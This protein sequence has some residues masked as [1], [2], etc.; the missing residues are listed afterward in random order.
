MT[1]TT[2]RPTTGKAGIGR[3]LLVGLVAGLVAGI[4]NL[5]VYF[6]SRALGAPFLVPLGDPTS[7]PVDLPIFAVVMACVMPGLIA[8]LVYWA[9]GR[10]TRNATRIFLI[11]SAVIAVV[12]LFPP[13]SLPID[14]GTRLSL[15]LMHLVAAP[16]IA[17]GLVRQAPQG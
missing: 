9:L 12:S 1:A 17:L 15:S 16:I 13:M 2:A 14:L 5:V 4:A 7:T 8:G 11:L 3:A 6:V 10:F